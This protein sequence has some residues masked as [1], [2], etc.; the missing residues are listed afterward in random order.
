MRVFIHG[1]MLLCLALNISYVQ[2]DPIKIKFAHV[3]A[4]STPKGMGAN[5][6]KKL[7]EER[8][9]GKVVVEVY[10]NSQLYGD[11][12]EMEALLLG[13][14]QMLAPSLAKFGKYTDKIQL[15][16]LP[17]LFDDLAAVDRFQ[18]SAKGQELLH[19]VE[20]KGYYGLAF[21]HNGMKQFSANKALRVPADAKGLKFRIQ[22]SKVLEAQFK[23]LGASPEKLAFSEVYNALATGIV[24]GAENPWANI[25][26]K[27]F[28]EVQKFFSETNHG[29]LD[30][31]VV[32]NTAF[33]KK[34]P[35]D[36]RAELEKI[37]AE[38]TVE[39]NKAAF[40]QEMADRQLVIDSGKTQVLQLT[41]EELQQWRTTMMPVWKQFED[42]IGKDLIEAAL[43]ANKKP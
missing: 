23:A 42:S 4:E 37:L 22:Q 16:D 34:L 32:T 14:V 15:F 8:L 10:P 28:H 17:F 5:L 41:P 27:K 39:V 25:Y 12:K 1:L 3:V 21:W 31:M 2:A 13:D 35:D 29:V 38:V 11:E 7:V 6:F 40:A 30:Y 26:S 43:A 18:A 33:W 9:A 24:D 20:K 19:S 36:I